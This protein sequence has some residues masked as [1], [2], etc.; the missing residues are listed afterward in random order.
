M[1]E[2][3]TIDRSS[4]DVGSVAEAL[5]YY[6]H[7]TLVTNAGSLVKFVQEFGGDNLLRIIDSGLLQL[8]YDQKHYIV[9]TVSN[10]IRFHDFGVTSLVKT[11]DGRKIRSVGDEIESIFIRE[12]G[13]S[14][15]TKKIAQD[16]ADRAS[17]RDFSDKVLKTVRQDT[18]D[19]AFITNAVSAWMAAMVPEYELPAN[20][21]IKTMDTGKGI[22]L[23]SGLDF[24]EI[25]KFYHRRI[26]PE[27]SS[28]TDAYLLANLMDVT[29]EII[30]GADA[31]SDLWLG[32]GQSAML[33]T[34]ISALAQRVDKSQAS[35]QIFHEIEFEGRTF[36][37]VIA[38]GEKTP[39]DLINFLE[40]E[41]TRKFKEW[42]AK[43][44]PDAALVK[45]Y[46]R[47]V[48]SKI[49]W[50]QRLP[51]RVGKLFAFGGLGA[52]VDAALGSMG[53]ASLTAIGMSAATDMLA[54]ASDEFVLSK[55]L[56]GWKPNQFVE[57]PAKEFLTDRSTRTDEPSS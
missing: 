15:A 41:D 27:H 33:R 4:V 46:D 30:F 45:E 36:R 11:A 5:V 51:F 12:I 31:D 7:V 44:D 52:G 54:S 18:L 21:N 13:A 48:F 38:S 3:V 16:L 8:T 56:K 20:F 10:P 25:N 57:G 24:E 39:R 47:A 1:F 14:H 19:Q 55:L 37:E 28:V 17:I 26:P 2:A 42:L 43:Q 22:L 40:H 35:T 29:R 34:K 53:L 49:G 23:V 32:P 6:G 9:R 50:T